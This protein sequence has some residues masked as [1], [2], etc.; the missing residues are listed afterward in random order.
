MAFCVVFQDD[1]VSLI[2]TRKFKILTM[3]KFGFEVNE[4]SW[5]KSGTLFFLTTGQ[6]QVEVR[7]HIIV[8]L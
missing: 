8:I 6:G 7:L 2:D 3:T 1:Q 5:N 4:L